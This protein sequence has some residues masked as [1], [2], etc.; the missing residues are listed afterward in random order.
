MEATEESSVY[1][2]RRVDTTGNEGAEVSAIVCSDKGNEVD[3]GDKVVEVIELFGNGAL[4]PV[5][6]AAK[7]N[8]GTCL[9]VTLSL[10]ASLT[11]D[12]GSD[13]EAP[14][15]VRHFR[16]TN[17]TASATRMVPMITE[18]TMAINLVL[19]KEPLSAE[20]AE[21]AGFAADEADDVTSPSDGD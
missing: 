13:L 21:D 14:A 18:T 4:G 17:Q 16:Q 5:E 9:L 19:L 10:D 1:L 12:C 3:V 11:F 6:A 2:S 7:W 8:A 20:E 15:R